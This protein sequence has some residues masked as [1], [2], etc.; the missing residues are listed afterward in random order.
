MEQLP[1]SIPENTDDY[2]GKDDPLYCGKCHTTKEAFFAKGIALM[3]KNKHPVECSCQRTEREKQETLISQQKHSD[4]VRRL[5]AEGF[6]DPAMLDWAFEND[7][8]CSPQ[9]HHA[10][11]YVEQWQAMRSE[12]LRLLLWG[13]VGT[14]K[15]FLAGCIANALME[16]EVPVHMTN[17]AEVHRLLGTAFQY[18]VECGIFVKSPVPVDCPK[19]STQERTIWTVEE[20]RAALNSMEDPILHLAVHLTLVGALREGEIVGLT[21]EDLDFDAADGIGTFRIN[22]SMQR[23]RKEAL[24]QVDDGCIIK[25]FPDKLERSTTSLI[26]K[27]TKTASSCRTIFMT[28]ALKEELKKLLNQLAADERKDPARCH[29]SGMLF[30]C[31]TVWW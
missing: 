11:R 24:N 26:L 12:N 21:P 13:G 1:S 27:S 25:V 7:N 22:K 30:R 19:K 9:M 23:V 31:P 8:G 3:G 17:F 29:D 16:Q 4:L 20:M 5:K 10:H 18:A 14:G 15:S 6:S 2:Y 28:S